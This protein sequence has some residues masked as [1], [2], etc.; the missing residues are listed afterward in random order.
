MGHFFFIFPA[1]GCAREVLRPGAR[2][3]Q[4]AQ[5]ARAAQDLVPCE[6]QAHRRKGHCFARDSHERAGLLQ[7]GGV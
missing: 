3:R 4:A 1:G 6:L 2:A 7:E 5:D